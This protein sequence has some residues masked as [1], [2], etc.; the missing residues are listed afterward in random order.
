M[1]GA[2]T[3]VVITVQRVSEMASHTVS[4]G[5]RRSIGGFMPPMP[6]PPSPVG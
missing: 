4:I 5:A 1:R 2:S 6:R 3:S